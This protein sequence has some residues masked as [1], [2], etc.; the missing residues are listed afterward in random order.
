MTVL[1][2]LIARQLAEPTRSHTLGDLAERHLLR[3]PRAS[4]ELL[5]LLARQELQALGRIR[6][7]LWL[8]PLL[9]TASIA[10][11]EAG[12]FGGNLLSTTT[13]PFPIVV[14]LL[15]A[16]LAFS[17]GLV[18]YRLAPVQGR[19]VLTLATYFGALSISLS[20]L[21]QLPSSDPLH[22]ALFVTAASLCGLFPITLGLRYA[23]AVSERTL[24]SLM[25]LVCLGLAFVAIRQPGRWWIAPLGSLTAWPVWAL[26][27]MASPG[28]TLRR[29]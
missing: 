15:A 20:F 26:L 2:L 10:V 11:T 8:P 22:L 3:T 1:N 27:Q 24:R 17:I 21:H 19:M 12:R 29:C 13:D 14:G 25:L 28:R 7:W 23:P 5:G 9:W 4:R 18:L 16:L 6:T